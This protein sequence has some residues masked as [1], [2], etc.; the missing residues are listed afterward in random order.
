MRQLQLSEEQ[1]QEM[2]AV[3][4]T[5]REF[6]AGYD[7]GLVPHRHAIHVKTRAVLLVNIAQY[8]SVLD[9]ATFPGMS[10]DCLIL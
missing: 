9:M 5:W 1:Q 3:R 6:L 7:V 8:C 2:L 10:H 4:K